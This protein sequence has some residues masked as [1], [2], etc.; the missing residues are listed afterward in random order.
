MLI[1]FTY[2]PNIDEL[3]HCDTVINVGKRAL[4]EHEFGV[5]VFILQSVL[6]EK[7]GGR[8]GNDTKLITQCHRLL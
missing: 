6:R 7:N 4:R 5:R 1:F 3:D 2:F 8:A